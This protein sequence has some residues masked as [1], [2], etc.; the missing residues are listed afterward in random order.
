MITYSQPTEPSAVSD[1][2]VRLFGEVF[3]EPPYYETD[4]DTAAFAETF[5]R[6]IQRPGFALVTAHDNS[7]LVGFAYGHTQ[8]PG[9]W[10]KDRA[11][12]P[13]ADMLDAEKF[14][15]Y[16]W[17]VA[18]RYRGNGIGQTMLEKLLRNR[19][20]PWATLSVNIAADAYRIYERTGWRPVGSRV[21]PNRP[22]MAAMARPLTAPP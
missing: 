15:V 12:P 17:A 16:E 7:T 1:Q 18:K 14:V 10:W 9:W 6:H 21:D 5:A 20:E 13:P 22:P 4:E 3:A 8:P 19:P 2:I 11:A